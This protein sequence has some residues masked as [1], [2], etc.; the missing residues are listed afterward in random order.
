MRIS[1]G[2]HEDIMRISWGYHGD[3]MGIS[4]GYH[5]DIIL[6]NLAWNCIDMIQPSIT[7]EPGQAVLTNTL[8]IQG[9]TWMNGHGGMNIRDEIH[10][11]RGQWKICGCLHPFLKKNFKLNPACIFLPLSWSS[12]FLSST[13]KHNF[14]A[15]VTNVSSVNSVCSDDVT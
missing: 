7:N 15:A 8:L 11:R 9:W 3:I 4:W 1:W 13:E 2:Y 6:L 5:G 10:R 14:Y 12:N